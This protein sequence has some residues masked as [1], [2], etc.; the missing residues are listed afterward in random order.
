M[1]SCGMIGKV[2]KERIDPQSEQVG[3]DSRKNCLERQ[4]SFSLGALCVLCVGL[5]SPK[6]AP[7][8]DHSSLSEKE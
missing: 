8:A 7:S 1:S 2:M 6:S 5:L 4:E 3:R